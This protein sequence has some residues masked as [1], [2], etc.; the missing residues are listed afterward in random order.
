MLH[1]ANLAA[2]EQQRPALLISGG[3]G[4]FL[5]C[6]T[7]VDGL[8][9]ESGLRPQDMIVVVESTRPAEV[10]SLFSGCMSEFDVRY[11]PGNIHWTKTNPLLNPYS[12]RDRS[13]RPARL[14]LAD[15][16]IEVF[17][18]WFLPF[19]AMRYER[20]TRRIESQ[21]ASDLDSTDLV[22]VSTRDKGFPWWLSDASVDAVHSNVPSGSRVFEIGSDDEILG[23]FGSR[24]VARSTAEALA[25]A[26]SARLLIGT[27]TGFAT[28]R[29]LLGLPNIYCVSPFWKERFMERFGY[30][31]ATM[32][33]RSQ[34][35]FAYDLEGLRA[36]LEHFSDAL[37]SPRSLASA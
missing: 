29:E 23:K 13:Q 21:F 12:E 20:S 6:L 10:R 34:S 36:A 22:L 8:L 17:E 16:G 27:D 18:D 32:D 2:R 1:Q 35:R 37:A 24:M 11:I 4:D 25:I 14:Y 33:S 5:H 3:I 26:C 9:A 31:S 7:F 15:R 30:W 28:V 19:L